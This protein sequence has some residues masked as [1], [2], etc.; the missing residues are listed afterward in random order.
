[1]LSL[2]GGTF[3]GTSLRLFPKLP[4]NDDKLVSLKYWG[5]RGDA[6]VT[7]NLMLFSDFEN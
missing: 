5:E 4:L 3:G 7:T 6:E 2:R 1:M